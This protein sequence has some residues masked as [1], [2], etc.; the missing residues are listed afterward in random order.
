[1]TDKPEQDDIMI[2]LF[3]LGDMR[4]IG[5]NVPEQ[6]KDSPN[7]HTL[8]LP[9]SAAME[10]LRRVL[11]RWHVAKDEAE[12]FCQRL[13]P[14]VIHDVLVIHQLLRVIFTNNSPGDYIQSPNKKFD[15]RTPWKAICDGESE[16]LRR[17][18]EHFVFN[19]GW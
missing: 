7:E 14:E 17:Y 1:M 18:L 8:V 16:H 9:I 12:A 13:S 5:I 4:M 19:G 11:E 2:P 15:G 6:F 3:A 10:L